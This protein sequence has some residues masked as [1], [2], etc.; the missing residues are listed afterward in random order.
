VIQN[1]DI[2]PIGCRCCTCKTQFYAPLSANNRTPHKCPACDG[3][4]KR[5]VLPVLTTVPQH[6]TCAACHGAGVVWEPQP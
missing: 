5:Q 6:E 2:H 3:W 1:I 4:G